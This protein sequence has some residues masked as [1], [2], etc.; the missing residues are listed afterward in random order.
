MKNIVLAMIRRYRVT[1]GSKCWFGVEC[2]FEPTCSAYTYDAIN[3]FGLYK[4]IKEGIGRI[5]N[6][7]QKD[8]VCKCIDPLE[9][10]G[11]SC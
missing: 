1:G 11:F 9:R 7:S 6:C 8:S 3:K 2:N 5:R 4:G 10:E